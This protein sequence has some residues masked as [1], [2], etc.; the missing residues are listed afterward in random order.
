[1]SAVLKKKKKKNLKSIMVGNKHI[2]TIALF[3]QSYPLTGPEN[4]KAAEFT[5]KL[6]NQPTLGWKSDSGLWSWD[7]LLFLDDAPRHKT[8]NYKAAGK[9]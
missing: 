3:I 8:R 2:P 6:T 9:L 1:M 4:K 5:L 7:Q